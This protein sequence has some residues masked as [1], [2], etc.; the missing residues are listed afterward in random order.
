MKAW[1]SLPQKTRREIFI[2]TGNRTG[3]PATAIEKDWWVMLALKAVAH[4]LQHSFATHLLEE[5]R[6]GAALIYA[7]Y[8]RYS[9]I[10]P[11]RLPISIPGRG[12]HMWLRMLL[13][14]SK[15]H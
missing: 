8:K 7:I 11:A 6:C 15:T 14:R 3:L 10:T 9:D 13:K 5:G 4:M 2:Q 12:I 1:F